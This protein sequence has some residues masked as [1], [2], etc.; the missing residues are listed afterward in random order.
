M[1]GLF[2]EIPPEEISTKP[3]AVGGGTASERP[4][5]FPKISTVE[6]GEAYTKPKLGIWRMF[7][8][9]WNAQVEGASDYGLENSFEKSEQE[10]NDRI[11]AAGYEP[12]E[13]LFFSRYNDGFGF[14]PVYL[15]A[16][17]YF[18]HGKINNPEITKLIQRRNAEIATL[19]QAHPELG[20]KDYNGLWKQTQQQVQETESRFAASTGNSVFA[21]VS[22]F[23]GQMAG[24]LNPSSDPLNFFTMGLGGVGRNVATRLATEA[25]IQGGIENLNQFGSVQ[26]K[27]ELL[28]L[29]H[30]TAQALEQVAL[31][32]AGGAAFRGAGELIGAGARAGFRAARPHVRSAAERAGWFRDRPDIGDPAPPPPPPGRPKPKPSG[33]QPAA[34]GP[35]TRPE[36]PPTP[37]GPSSRPYGR[38]RL[39][40][41]RE[42]QDIVSVERQLNDPDGPNPRDVKPYSEAPPDTRPQTAGEYARQID[43]KVFQMW[44]KLA[45]EAEFLRRQVREAAGGW[46]P[47]SDVKLDLEQKIASFEAHANA[48]TLNRKQLEALRTKIDKLRLQREAMPSVPEELLPQPTMLERIR[49]RVKPT[50]ETRLRQIEQKLRDL[51]PLVERA[52]AAARD[53]FPK[54]SIKEQAGF[55]AITPEGATSVGRAP[56]DQVHANTRTTPPRPK[57]ESPRERPVEARVPEVNQRP[58]VTDKLPADADAA[59]KLAAIR[60]ADQKIQDEALE[61]FQQKVAEALKPFEERIAVPPTL[62]FVT[63]EEGKQRGLDQFGPPDETGKRQLRGIPAVFIDGKIFTGHDHTAAIDAAVQALGPKAAERIDANPEQHIGYAE[64]NAENLIQI[65]GR[66]LHLDDDFIADPEGRVDERGQPVMLTIREYIADVQKDQD[67]LKA[68]GTCSGG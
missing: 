37:A 55:G 16:A 28:G 62:K 47:T 36:D 19:N 66:T 49:Q 29:E 23:V 58:E 59:D 1:A 40:A 44:N 45:I 53:E 25:A 50:G 43:P 67:M 32:A 5:L 24:A 30:G 41:L 57:P 52:Y 20:L 11:R 10:Q 65:D 14:K 68:M 35:R 31:T 64:P 54:L 63:L 13:A 2:A 22:G 61:R 38:S 33:P 39:G 46:H 15:D 9:G 26:Y 34:G 48:A 4:A 27:R 56:V 42:E 8:A 21:S 7:E 60:A 12:P 17:D 51:V 6:A 3:T 18:V